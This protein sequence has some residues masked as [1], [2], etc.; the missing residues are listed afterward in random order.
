MLRMRLYA[1]PLRHRRFELL[2][3]L[4]KPRTIHLVRKRDAIMVC[5]DPLLLLLRKN[6]YI[7]LLLLLLSY[8]LDQILMPISNVAAHETEN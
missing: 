4:L 2:L 7:L 1:G 3:M 8:G 6:T 5:T